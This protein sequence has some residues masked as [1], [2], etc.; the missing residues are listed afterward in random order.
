LIYLGV[1][2]IATSFFSGAFEKNTQLILKSGLLMALTVLAS[3]CIV[4]GP[5][6]G[7][8]D[9]GGNRYYHQNAWHDCSERDEH[10]R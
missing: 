5:H 4:P 3:A 6:E 7:Y 9:H 1:V 2:A 10:C 8:Y